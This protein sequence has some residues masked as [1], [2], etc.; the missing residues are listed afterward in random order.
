MTIQMRTEGLLAPPNATRALIVEDRRLLAE[1]LKAVLE[2][3][4]MAAE[5]AVEPTVAAVDAAV[6]RFDPTVAIVAVGVGSGS[7]T[8]Q[9][10]GALCERGV[11]VV[12]MTG[13][14]D[15]V[16]LARCVEEGAVAI[17]DKS[18]DVATLIHLA[19]DAGTANSLLAPTERYR[20]DDALREHRAQRRAERRPLEML[21]PRERE[22]LRDLT[23]GF[24][25]REIAERSFVSLSTVRSQIKSI[26]AKLNT[27]SQVQ[28]ISMAM[29]S[30]WF[31]PTDPS[32]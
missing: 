24:R 16:R 8:E 28:A 17:I 2:A 27:R 12:V 19:H 25:A 15:R 1:S 6:T 9:I 3:A 11:P 21:T 26:L 5:L 23:L 13:G 4:G 10:I 22:V 29:R 20:L 14:S 32:T 18:M 31:G 30:H 7:L